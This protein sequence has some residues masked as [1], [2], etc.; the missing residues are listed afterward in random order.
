MT[1]QDLLDSPEGKTLEFKENSKSLPGIVKTVVAFANT[2][3][4]IIVI[5]VE[6]RTKKVVGI[7]NAL[8]EE[9]RLVST[10]YDSIAPTIIPDI[11]IINYRKKQLIIIRI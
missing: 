6:D 5:G 9:E 2:A 10:I 3:G 11:D 1:I 8:A 4:G 7:E